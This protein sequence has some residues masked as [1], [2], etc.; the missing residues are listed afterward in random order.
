MAQLLTGLQLAILLDELKIQK[1]FS[2]ESFLG[3]FP[4]ND[5]Q[6]LS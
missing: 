3:V 4:E 5:T 1:T 6:E 2:I